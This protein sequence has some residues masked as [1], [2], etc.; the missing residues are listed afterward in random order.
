MCLGV[1][2]CACACA[3]TCVRVHMRVRVRVCVRACACVCVCVF[4][5][6][7][8]RARACARV[9][10]CVCVCLSVCLS[11]CVRA[12]SGT[13]IAR[14]GRAVFIARPR[15]ADG[16]V[17]FLR[18][19]IGRRC[20][21]AVRDRQRA[22]GFAKWAHFR[23]RRRRRHLRHRRQQLRQH[24]RHN[25][26]RRVGERRRRCGPDSGVY[27]SSQGEARVTHWYSQG[28]SGYSEVH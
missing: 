14:R 2:A 5:C 6:V 9:C 19:L 28:T 27:R 25:L 8:V 22:V 10:A 3:C 21:V 7:C 16:R 24:A 18:L 15:R 12:C 26:Q 17:C 20:D 4:V 11:F 13:L 1:C 23:D